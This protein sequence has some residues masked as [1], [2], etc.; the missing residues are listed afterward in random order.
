MLEPLCSYFDEKEL[1]FIVQGTMFVCSTD[2]WEDWL[3]QLF[4]ASSFKLRLRN[5]HE[6]WAKEEYEV[7]KVYLLFK[8]TKQKQHKTLWMS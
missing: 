2:N 1:S 6:R 8:K 5:T 3:S 4:C 7:S